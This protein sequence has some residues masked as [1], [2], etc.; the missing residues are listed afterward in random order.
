[1]G[2]GAEGLQAA[3]VRAVVRGAGAG[4][5]GAVMRAGGMR[6]GDDAP[7]HARAHGA[8]AAEGHFLN[9]AKVLQKLVP[10]GQLCY[11]FLR[12]Y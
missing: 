4:A 2:A 7:L 6:A 10:R 9:A 5:G 11:A 1:M 12:L 8:D 3:R